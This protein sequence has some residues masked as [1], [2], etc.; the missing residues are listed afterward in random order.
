MPH[1]TIYSTDR[2]LTEIADCGFYEGSQPLATAALLTEKLKPNAQWEGF[3]IA[4]LFPVRDENEG[5]TLI[6]ALSL[7]APEVREGIK[8]SARKHFLSLK[9][10]AIETKQF[11]L[12]GPL[13]YVSASDC[14]RINPGDALPGSRVMS[15][16]AGDAY[17][18]EVPVVVATDGRQFEE[19]AIREWLRV[20][21]LS[22][23]KEVESRR[24]TSKVYP[25]GTPCINRSRR[26]VKG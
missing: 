26:K 12:A 13:P 2:Q 4:F 5:R 22:G 9:Y 14:L 11:E 18:G 15:H 19:R 24:K 1:V 17:G 3:P 25:A 23:P 10:V 16:S 6:L 21:R 8:K 20:L 7:L